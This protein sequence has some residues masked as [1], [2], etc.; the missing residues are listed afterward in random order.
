MCNLHK[1]YWGTS[2]DRF[3]VDGWFLDQLLW[4]WHESWW[5]NLDKRVIHDGLLHGYSKL[6]SDVG[7]RVWFCSVVF[8]VIVG[9]GVSILFLKLTLT[10]NVLNLGL[11]LSW[12]LLR[13]CWIWIFEFVRIFV[14]VRP[15]RVLWR[16]YI[17]FFFIVHW[18]YDQVLVYTL[19]L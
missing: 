5:I 2:L 6:L 8:V 15:C 16:I 10:W 13:I 12:C 7:V 3:V 1:R 4:W 9:F 17:L 14:R 19:F 11:F 18:R